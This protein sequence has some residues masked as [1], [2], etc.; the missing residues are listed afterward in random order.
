MGWHGLCNSRGMVNITNAQVYSA[1]GAMVYQIDYSNGTSVRAVESRGQI[2]RNE[3]K[4][5]QGWK[6]AGKEYKVDHS[7]H[8]QAEKIKAAAIATL[9]AS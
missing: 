7:K 4:T 2:I 3:Y 1:N 5:A 6:Q 9:L 8:R